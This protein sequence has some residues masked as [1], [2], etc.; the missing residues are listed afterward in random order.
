MKPR[1]VTDGPLIKNRLSS[2]PLFTTIFSDSVRTRLFL[3]ESRRETS[4]S[5]R[6]DHHPQAVHHGDVSPQP[7]AHQ[8]RQSRLLQSPA[9]NS[10]Y[11]QHD[12]AG[13]LITTSDPARH[14]GQQ[15]LRTA[16]RRGCGC[17]G[18]GRYDRPPPAIAEITSVPR[19]AT[20][21]VRMA[22]DL[23]LAPFDFLG[24]HLKLGTSLTG[25]SNEG[26]LPITP[27]IF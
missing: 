2:S 9:G 11:R 17:A 24:T 3:N 15:H 13:T 22:G 23:S 26:V 21:G 25:S 4:T 6:L 19:T 27:S 1:F 20:P 10:R 8:L 7:A 18:A 12:Y 16:R 14:P 5:A